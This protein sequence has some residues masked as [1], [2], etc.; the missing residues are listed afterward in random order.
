MVRHDGRDISGSGIAV[1]FRGAG[2]HAGEALDRLRRR[3]SCA[4]KVDDGPCQGRQIGYEA[5]HLA[6]DQR[7]V[8]RSESVIRTTFAAS[9]RTTVAPL[10]ALAWLAVTEPKSEGRAR[11]D[12]DQR[13]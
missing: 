13:G 11:D 7:G 4:G 5:G 12:V 1:R 10:S 3:R 8:A 9:I 6:A 2:E